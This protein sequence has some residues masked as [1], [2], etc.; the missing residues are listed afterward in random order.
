[1]KENNEVEYD[2]EMVRNVYRNGEKYEKA[3]FDFVNEYTAETPD[4]PDEPD[5]PGKKTNKPDTGDHNNFV[6]PAAIFAAALIAF[7]VAL[8][9]RRKQKNGK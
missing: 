2:A 4:E 3:T 5:N 7:I 9:R 8:V 1:M 6:V